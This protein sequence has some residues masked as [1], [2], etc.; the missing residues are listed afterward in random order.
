ML[1]IDFRLRQFYPVGIRGSSDIQRHFF[2]SPDNQGTAALDS[3]SRLQRTKARLGESMKL[4]DF[5]LW[6]VVV[7]LSYYVQAAS[8]RH[9]AKGS[10]SRNK[11]RESSAVC[12]TYAGGQQCEPYLKG[13]QVYVKSSQPQTTKTTIVSMQY[14]MLDN[15]DEFVS[16][17]C[18]HYVL[19]TLCH[20]FFPPCDTSHSEP[21]PRKFCRGDCFLLKNDI[22]KREFEQVKELPVVSKIFPDCLQMPTIRDVGDKKCIQIVKEVPKPKFRVSMDD[23]T[24]FENKSVIFKCRLSS[25]D[26]SVNITWYKDNHRIG[27]SDRTYKITAFR[28]GSRLRIRRARSWHAGMFE[29]MVQGPGGVVAKKA[30]LKIIGANRTSS[31]AKMKPTSKEGKTESPSEEALP[32]GNTSKE[33]S[34]GLCEKYE[35]DACREFL[36]NKTIWMNYHGHQEV[37]EYQMAQGLIASK[38]TEQLSD[39]CV[40][41]GIPAMCYHIFP[42]CDSEDKDSKPRLCREDCDAL[43]ENVCEQE[44]K[45]ASMDPLYNKIL[46]DC[47]ILPSRGDKDYSYCSPLHIPGRDSEFPT[48]YETVSSE[49]QD[50]TCFN[51]RGTTY[52]GR[53]NVS[54]SGRPCQQWPEMDPPRHN[55]CR[56]PG[57]VEGSPWCLVGPKNERESCGISRCSHVSAGIQQEKSHRPVGRTIYVISAIMAVLVVA[58]LSIIVYL[59]VQHSKCALPRSDRASSGSIS[60]ST[61]STLQQPSFDLKQSISEIKSCVFNENLAE[62]THGKVKFLEALGEGLF[63]KVCKGALVKVD[64]DSP[65]VEIAVKRLKADVPPTAVE[66]FKREIS[67]LAN[68]QDINILCMIGVSASEEPRFMLFEY[69]T[70]MD[71]YRFLVENASKLSGLIPSDL[72]EYNV[73]LDFALQIASGMDFLVENNFV[74]RDLAARNVYVAEDNIVKISNLGIGSY[75]YPG[76]YSWVHSSALLPVRWMA[77]EALNTLQ[78]SHRTDVW[79]YGVLLWELYSFGSQPYAGLSN[80]EAIEQIRDLQVLPCPDQCPARMY[81][82]MREECWEEDPSERPAFSEICSRLRE[83][84]GDSIAESH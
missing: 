77:P 19:P 1:C 18:K 50:H 42:T 61:Q 8:R 68:L 44:L 41:Y 84:A 71:L 17:K 4:T 30:R 80:Q 9:S 15:L 24:M 13:V 5:W 35:G 60:K 12:E 49:V 6:A 11:W 56:N 2:G 25:K 64:S 66:N 55:F 29:C 27:N 73:L 70:D 21:K 46:P 23:I 43:Y 32:S 83:W 79:S 67:I 16:P 81:G 82:L 33:L 54:E 59:K 58:F 52:L 47:S 45:F 3:L 39:S 37:V 7:A 10:S 72:S 74:H 38:E 31:P 69:Y 22:C 26:I 40:K 28:W 78:F 48:H 51:K 75:K 76:D 36:G 53:R 34:Y 20:Y 63:A 57:N 14:S 62:V 65:H